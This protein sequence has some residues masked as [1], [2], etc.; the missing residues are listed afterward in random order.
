MTWLDRG[1]SC[2]K[3]CD[4]IKIKITIRIKIKIIDA[5]NTNFV[6]RFK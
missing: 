1:P 4:Q 5:Q 3:T 6:P 2:K